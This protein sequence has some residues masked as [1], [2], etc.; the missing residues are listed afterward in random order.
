MNHA[1]KKLTAKLASVVVCIALCV[2]ALSQTV[3]GARRDEYIAPAAAK[4]TD[5]SDKF[6]LGTLREDYFNEDV[7]KK[8]PFDTEGEIYAIVDLGGSGAYEGYNGEGEFSDYLTTASA[9]ARVR[10]MEQAQSSVLRRMKRAGIDYELRYSYTAVNNALA[11][12]VDS[13]DFDKLSQIAGVAGVYRSETYDVPQ[14]VAVSNNANVYSTGIY[15]SSDIEYKGDGMVV[16]ILD[17]GFDYTHPAFSAMPPDSEGRWEK[18]DVAAKLDE[19]VAKTELSPD[20]T[21]DDVF[22]NLKV[23]YAYDYADSDANVFPSYSAHGTHV[24]GIVAG[25]DDTK[26]VNT[27]TGETFVGVAPNAQLAIM[28]VFTDNLDSRMLGGADTV[29]ILAAINDC[30]ALGVDVINMSLGSAGGFSDESHDAYLNDTYARVEDLGI[31]L[32]VAVG[33][34]YSSGFGGGNGTNLASNPD[35]GTAGSPSTYSAALAVASINGQES[36][37]F[38]AN[39]SAGKEG[40]VAFLTEASDANGNEFDFIEGIYEAVDA[41]PGEPLTL[42]YV[43]VDGVG[44]PINYTSAVRNALADGRTLALVRRGDT[45]FEEKVETAMAN[46]AVGVII[47]NNVS[48][49]IRM[50]LG[51]VENPVPTCSIGMDAGRLMVD[52]AVAKVGTVTFSHG[53]TAGPFMS[54][55]SSWGPTPDLKLKPEI[56]A[57]GGEITSSVPGGYDEYSGTSMAA[58]NMSGAVA[59]LR[60]HV[61]A[62]EGLTGTALRARVNQLLM[63]TATMA[64]NEEG[65]PYSPRKQGAGLAGIAAAI[66]TESFIYVKDA[67]GNMLDK[68]KLELGDDKERTGV[69]TMEFTV[70]NISGTAATYTPAAYVMTETLASDNK[71]VAEKSYMLGSTTVFSVGGQPVSSV[72]VPA[73]GEV[74]VQA[75]ITLSAADRE[76]I[77]TSFVN[78]MYVE[79]FLRLT[80]S[81]GAEVDLGV[82]FLAFYGDWTDAP[83]FDYTTYEIS[84]SVAEEED[85]DDQLKATAS[86]STPLGLYDDG[87]Y[88]MPL[89]TYLYNMSEEDTEIVASDEKA[90]VSIYDTT[91]RKTMY[92]LYMIYAG[93]LRGAKTLHMTIT[94]AATGEVVFDRTDYNAR[95]SYAGGGANV[96]SPVLLEI[97]PYEWGMANNRSYV[98]EMTGTLDYEGGEDPAE[99]SFSFTFCADYEAPTV[100]DYRIRFEP[101]TENRETKYRIY[102]DVDVYDNQFAQALLPCYVKDN[103][104]Y[105]LRQYPVPIY[106][107]KNSVTTVSFEITDI[108]DDYVATGNFYIGVEDYAMN[109]TIYQVNAAA[110]TD[111]PEQISFETGDRLVSTGTKEQNVVSGG[112]TVKNVY[113]TYEIELQPNEAFTLTPTALPEGTAATK[114]EWT[115]SNDRVLAYENELFAVREGQA[116]ATLKADG[117]IRAQISVTVAGEAQTAPLLERITFRPILNATEYIDDLSSGGVELNPNSTV[118]LSVE[119]DPWYCTGIELEWESSNTDVLT[120]DGNGLVTTHKKGTAFVTVRAKGYDRMS[121]TLRVQVVDEF[122]VVNYTLMRYYGGPDVVIPDDL[123]VLYIDEDAFR[124]NTDIR[125]VTISKTVAEI[126]EYAFENCVNLESVTI[127]SECTLIRERAFAGCVNLKTLNLLQFQDKVDET[128]YDTGTLTL[129]RY[130]FYNCRSLTDIVNPQRIMTVRDHA[131]AGCTSLSSLDLTGLRVSDEYVFENCTLLGSVTMDADTAVAPYMFAGCTSLEEIEYFGTT[132]PDGMFYNCTALSSVTLPDGLTYIG[133]NAFAGTAVTSLTLPDG[134]VSVGANAFAGTPL[135][136][137]TLSAGTVIDTASLTPFADCASFAS[138][139]VEAGNTRYAAEGGILYN[140]AKTELVLLPPAVGDF[141]LPDTVTRIGAGAFAGRR[142]IGSLDLSGIT[143]IGAYAFAGSN[144]TSIAIPASVTEIAEGAFYNCTSLRTVT[145]AEGVTGIDDYAFYGCSALTGIQ[146]PASVK[147][148]GDYAFDGSGLAS[149]DM[150]G[151]TTAGEYAFRN[152]RLSALEAPVLADIGAYAFA[153]NTLLSSVTLGPV[154]AMGDLAFYGCNNLRSVTFGNGS[155]IVGEGAFMR[156]T[157]GGALTSVTLPDT[158][159][160]IGQLAFYNCTALT[161]IDLSHVKTIGLGAFAGC[162]GLTSVDLSA[163]TDIGAAAFFQTTGIESVSLD[164][165]KII[166]EAAFEDSGLTS[167]TMPVAERIGAYAFTGT[168]LTSVTIPA[169]LNTL[170]YADSWWGVSDSGKP[171]LVEGKQTSRYG[172]GAFSGIPTLTEILVADD[173]KTFASFDGVLYSRVPDGWQLEQYPAAKSGTSYTM[174]AGTVRV[175]DS[176]FDG[177]TGLT[178]VTAPYTLQSIGS[179]AFYNS[180]VKRYVFEAVEAP[181]LEATYVSPESVAGNAELYRL[182][183]TASVQQVGSRIFYANFYDYVAKVVEEKALHDAGHTSYVA[184]DF[185]LTIVRPENGTGYDSII[186]NGF[187]TTTELSPY[188]AQRVTRQAI[189]LIDELPA[190]ADVRAILETGSADEQIAAVRSLSETTVQPARSMYNLITTDAQRAFVTNYQ[191]LLDVEDAVR[192]VKSELGIAAQLTELSLRTRPTKLQYTAGETFDPTGMV[193]VAV[194]D[195]L[196]EVT[197]TDYTLDKS[198]LAVGDTEVVISYG[199]ASTVVYVTVS[200]AENT[201]PTDPSDPGDAEKGCGCGGNIAAASIPAAV[202][203][204]ALAFALVRRRPD[205]RNG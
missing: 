185:G 107:E 11:V 60:Q 10:D 130:A 109:Q 136:T 120:V 66:D 117:M 85:V 198:T 111:Y 68:T 204:L 121:R 2:T 6:D 28:K 168:A 93:L 4:L 70:K 179:Y 102:M 27:S 195:D 31:S 14:A 94:D 98:F 192:T 25:K 15:D 178:E 50:S 159:T 122:Y 49:T 38:M 36:P 115:V 165:A 104:L 26:V 137:L 175:G 52:G 200:A 127:P 33:N 53:Y 108:Y 193:V 105:L 23:P 191:T 132:V 19:T 113:N 199:G 133:E 138:V 88:I 158:V 203:L 65:N 188:A 119:F 101:Y 161:T 114:L 9:A 164:S 41:D 205:K 7:V 69:Y 90:A 197:V 45:S 134:N 202:I 55:F 63:S 129:G 181:V 106:S 184:P 150:P 39:E 59:L 180:S 123:N 141:T 186:W 144:L 157:A 174:I 112:Q 18:E 128:H 12:R 87:L 16:A 47:Y 78:G 177:V 86:P 32:V 170:T 139:V 135:T 95:K 99:N 125:S 166:G 116:T 75:Q 17:S 171:E 34:E 35:S 73:D 92:Q 89:G 201:D 147:Y 42:N 43:V 51:D 142:D 74:T 84:E 62:T 153:E 169:S 176:A 149:V 145:I 83:L 61:T 183:G 56:T 40:T 124:G 71:T 187:F 189:D 140:A 173:N 91:S 190:V 3:V 163:A 151:V 46:G 20:L 82:P 167:V 194:Y 13:A 67:E 156:D 126:D 172:I 118:Q 5:V 76:Y 21:V 146:L 58:P 29:D 79:G 48:G 54:D 160:E 24:A 30:A 103:T 96:G 110:A 81:E 57:H 1:R 196:S 162:T 80:A 100:R 131:F 37:Y 143:E 64:L 44:R 8:N 22:Y 155:T 97:N 148:V 182:F 77:E 72:T 154:T 152:T